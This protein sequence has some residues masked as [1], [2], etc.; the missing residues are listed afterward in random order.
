MMVHEKGRWYNNNGSNYCSNTSYW[1]VHFVPYFA[2]KFWR[3][4]TM[5]PESKILLTFHK[6]ED[7]CL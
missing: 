5:I 7:I 3:G 1:L 6:N 4:R 2:K